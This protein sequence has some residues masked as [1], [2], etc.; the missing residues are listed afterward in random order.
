MRFHDRT[1]E[2]EQ[3]RV[4]LALDEDETVAVRHR[5]VPSSLLQAR[6]PADLRPGDDERLRTAAATFV[7]NGTRRVSAGR[8]APAPADGIAC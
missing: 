8:A 5:T 2:N 6:P 3:G 1:Y 4:R 7:V